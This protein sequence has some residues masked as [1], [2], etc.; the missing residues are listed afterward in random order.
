M[1]GKFKGEGCN[2]LMMD[3]SVSAIED[4]FVLVPPQRHLS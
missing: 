2:N 4:G 1:R 3:W